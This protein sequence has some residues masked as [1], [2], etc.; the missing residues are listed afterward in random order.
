MSQGKVEM[1]I[2]E[3]V[4]FVQMVKFQQYLRDVT[5]LALVSVGNSDDGNTMVMVALAKPLPLTSILKGIPPVE[6]VARNGKA[7]NVTLK[8][9][10]SALNHK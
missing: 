9:R 7:I 8:A 6:A 2:T 1:C 10:E 5:D 3:P 4:D